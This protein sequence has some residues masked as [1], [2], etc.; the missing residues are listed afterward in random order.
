VTCRADSLRNLLGEPQHSQ[1]PPS[2]CHRWSS[3]DEPRLTHRRETLEAQSLSAFEAP[4]E[5]PSALGNPSPRTFSRLGTRLNCRGRSPS[6][7]FA[8]RPRVAVAC[9]TSSLRNL[10]G[11]PQHGPPPT[12]CRPPM[13]LL[14]R[15]ESGL[16]CPPTGN[17][18]AENSVDLLRGSRGARQLRVPRSSL[19][20]QRWLPLAETVWRPT[21]SVH[22]EEPA[23]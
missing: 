3:S 8:P 22:W 15:A 5:V 4:C 2:V 6:C 1:R 12:Q 9:L 10:F 21:G 13:A 7:P 11:N 19:D 16:P 14:G 17:R 20:I 18:A 23:P